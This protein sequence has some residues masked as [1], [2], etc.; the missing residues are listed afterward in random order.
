MTGTQKPKSP[1][2]L[3]H[4]L[5]P[6]HGGCRETLLA[7]FLSLQGGK[8][9]KSSKSW[10]KVWRFNISPRCH[11]FSTEARAPCQGSPKC[12]MDECWSPMQ[13]VGTFDGG[14]RCVP[15]PGGSLTQFTQWLWEGRSNFLNLLCSCPGYSSQ[16]E[17]GSGAPCQAGA[18]GCTG[19]TSPGC[20]T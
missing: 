10:E 17:E 13:L 8:K 16:T 2:N 15:G 1:W 9:K 18:A 6:G 14:Q 5:L 4:F 12:P 11:V 20:H 3:K 7:C 19:R